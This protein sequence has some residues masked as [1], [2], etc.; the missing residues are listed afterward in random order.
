MT[1]NSES[2]FYPNPV[3]S[4]LHLKDIEKGTELK[5]FDVTGQLVLKVELDGEKNI[6]VSPLPIGMYMVQLISNKS[7]NTYKLIKE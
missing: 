4:L 1:G 7:F 6:N 3:H 2:K 5:V